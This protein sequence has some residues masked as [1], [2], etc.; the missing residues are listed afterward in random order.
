M[1]RRFLHFEAT[2]VLGTSLGNFTVI[3]RYVLQRCLAECPVAILGPSCDADFPTRSG[4]PLIRK[5]FHFSTAF[6]MTTLP[7]PPTGPELG[8]R[9][10]WPTAFAVVAVTRTKSHTKHKRD[11]LVE[12]VP[13]RFHSQELVVSEWST[14]PCISTGVI[15]REPREPRELA[16]RGVLP[17]LAHCSIH[18]QV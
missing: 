10:C 16:A 17:R 13:T 2:R 3:S 14:C 7:L 12:R 15:P 8:N 1:I 11:V 9:L 18:A 4:C 5:L 6:P